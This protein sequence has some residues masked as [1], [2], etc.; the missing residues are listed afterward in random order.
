M[1]INTGTG[2]KHSVEDTI[3][4][5]YNFTP[6]DIGTFQYIYHS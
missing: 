3:G 4:S 6:M 5:V 1:V 2:T